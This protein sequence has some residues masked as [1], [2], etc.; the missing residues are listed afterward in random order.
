MKRNVKKVIKK[1]NKSILLCL[2]IFITLGAISGYF[3]MNHLTKNDTFELV[4][5]KNITLTLN[6][7]YIEQGVNVI[8]FGKDLKDKVVIESNLDTSKEGE[9]TIIYTINDSFKYKDVKRIRYISVVNG[10]D[11][12]G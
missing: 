8:A 9:Y 11:N 2:F 3:S 4:G 5:E 7:E 6:Q 10:S 1:T 12:N